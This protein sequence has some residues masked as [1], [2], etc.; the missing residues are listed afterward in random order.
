MFNN[1]EQA[2][3]GKPLPESKIWNFFIQI[4]LGMHHV[5]GKKIL[6]R[7]LKTMNLFLDEQNRIKIGDLGV[8]RVLG[9]ASLARTVVF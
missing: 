3:G 9:T 5:H 8:A 1:Y 7:D 2:R 6:H 4:L